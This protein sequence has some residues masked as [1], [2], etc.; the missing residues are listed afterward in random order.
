MPGGVA[1]LRPDSATGCAGRGP[2]N[3]RSALSRMTSFFV[4]LFERVM[5]D[6]FVFVILLTL[7]TAVL[8]FALV[9]DAT[10]GKIALAW[11]DGVFRILTFGFQMVLIL[12]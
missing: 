11:N 6:P 8:S 10:P 5:P 9:P 4:Y 1:A 7:I 2:G 3:S 12:S